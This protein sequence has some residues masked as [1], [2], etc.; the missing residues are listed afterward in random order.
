MKRLLA[1]LVLA[2]PL[3]AQADYLDVMEIRLREDC[4]FDQYLQIIKAFNEWA[5]DWDYR[6]DLARPLMGSEPEVLYWLGRAPNTETFGRAWDAWREAQR[7]PDSRPA[8]LGSRL[9][10]CHRVL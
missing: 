5:A 10:E 4:S 2:L 9:R 1:A 7:D 8:D 3:A 6:A